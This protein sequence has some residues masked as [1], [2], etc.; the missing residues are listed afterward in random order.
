MDKYYYS[1]YGSYKN[2]GNYGYKDV[3]EKE[4]FSQKKLIKKSEKEQITDIIDM[5]IMNYERLEEETGLRGAQ[6]YK[7]SYNVHNETTSLLKAKLCMSIESV[8]SMM[9]LYKRNFDEDF[10]LNE[11]KSMEKWFFERFTPPKDPDMKKILK[12][13]YNIF[14]GKPFEPF[15]LKEK[16]DISAVFDDD[17]KSSFW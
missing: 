4:K 14:K 8:Y 6:L 11:Y 12:N 15:E 3:H 10:P 1:G 2:Y 9:M 16:I 7:S 13:I 5:T 17:K